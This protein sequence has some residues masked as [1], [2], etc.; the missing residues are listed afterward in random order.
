MDARH[1]LLCR[2]DIK[3]PRLI[4]GRQQ[5]RDPATNAKQIVQGV[6]VFPPGKASRG[7]ST[8]RGLLVAIHLNELRPQ[9]RQRSGLR[10]LVRPSLRRRGHFSAA[11]AI[12]D[13]NPRAKRI[14]I[15]EI[16][17]ELRQVKTSLGVLVVTG[18][19]RGFDQW[20]ELIIGL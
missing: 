6:F 11:D 4:F 10:L 19:A 8:I 14:R 12:E 17:A 1:P 20:L 15:L 2:N 5:F 16:P 13:A 3:G 7:H 18:D 9:K